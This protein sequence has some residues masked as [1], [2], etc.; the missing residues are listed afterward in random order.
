MASQ[1]VKGPMMIG[2]L[3]HVT[4]FKAAGTAAVALVA[5]TNLPYDGLEKIGAMGI[6][7]VF[8]WFT[9]TRL[10]TA[11]KENSSAIRDLRDHLNERR[12]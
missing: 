11:I 4:W 8:V 7:A 9:L 12:S 6:L 1:A 2:N 10:E 5:D 3:L